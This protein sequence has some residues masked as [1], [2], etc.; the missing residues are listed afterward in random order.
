MTLLKLDN[1]CQRYP[2]GKKGWLGK[3]AQEL[4]A[5]NKISLSLNKGETLAIVGESGCGKSTLGRMVALLESPV[6]GGVEIDGIQTAGLK[7]Q[8]LKDLRRK[9]GL[10]FQD[11]YSALNPR[12]P[13]SELVGEP[14]DVYNVGDKAS[15]KAKV[16]EALKAVGLSE[17]ALDR[18]PH[19]FSGGQRQRICIARALVLD[20]KLII[21]DEPLSALDVSVQSQVLNLFAELQRERNLSFFF[22]SHDM[23]VVDYLA[24]TIVVM[25]LGQVVEQAPRDAFFSKP[26]HPYSQALLAA[27]P[28]VGKGKRKRGLALQG[29]VPSPIDPPNGCTF[30]PRC[31]K[32]TEKCKTEIPVA[33]AYQDDSKHI[34]A[35]HYPGEV[36]DVKKMESEEA[37]V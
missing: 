28:E 13:I 15:R 9:L 21:A 19:E 24:D 16:I 17:D 1:V 8:A 20:P 22:I 26:A 36:I 10:V 18:Y 5:V 6:E 27:V 11:P 4:R 3:P 32:A 37:T 29:D 25:Y 34:V 33:S 14:L 2:I 12:L 35:C 23:A 7:G 31:A 30:H